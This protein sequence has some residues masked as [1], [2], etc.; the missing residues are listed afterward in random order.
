MDLDRFGRRLALVLL[1]VVGIVVYFAPRPEPVQTEAALG[2]LPDPAG[3]GIPPSEASPL[4]KALNE[5]G[6]AAL[7]PSG[8]LP[9]APAPPPPREHGVNA[10]PKSTQAA[11]DLP[12]AQ[13]ED[14]PH[15]SGPRVRKPTV[16]LGPCGGVTVRGI[17]DSP[18]PDWAF[19]MLAPMP[20]DRAKIS[21][22]GDPI[23]SYRVQSIEWDRVWLMGPGG[24]CAVRLAE[25]VREAAESVGETPLV[26]DPGLKARTEP[27]RLSREISNSIEVVGATVRV[28]AGVV[29]ALFDRGAQWISGVK[30]VPKREAERAVGVVFDGVQEGSL[31]HHVGIRSGDL[32]RTLD[33][34]PAESLARIGEALLAARKEKRVLLELERDGERLQILVQMV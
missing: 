2:A 13:A 3:I 26:I 11:R 18:D 12:L 8:T 17:T 14:A 5:R 27:W 28:D 20:T 16:A 4:G 9:V 30:V 33:S 25:G 32:L 21:R 1:P 19:A 31:L 7:A 22:A 15:P 10:P 6:E 24:R 29:D 23:G 34:T